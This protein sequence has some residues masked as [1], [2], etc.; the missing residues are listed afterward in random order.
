MHNIL[1]I[2]NEIPVTE[3][4]VIQNAP[5]LFSEPRLARI[6][7]STY[8]IG[9]PNDESKGSSFTGLRWAQYVISASLQRC[10]TLIVHQSASGVKATFAFKVGN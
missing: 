10:Y 9:E 6:N 4:F 1:Q 5:L 8:Y 3:S 7:I 2:T